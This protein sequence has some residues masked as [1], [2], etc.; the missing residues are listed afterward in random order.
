MKKQLILVTSPPACG[1]TYVSEKLSET[2]KPIIYLDKDT[3]IPLSEQVYKAA[4]VEVNRSGVASQY[5]C[6]EQTYDSFSPSPGRQFQRILC[7]SGWIRSSPRN[8]SASDRKEEQ[9]SHQHRQP[10]VAIQLPA[11]NDYRAEN[12]KTRRHSGPCT[13]T[14][15]LNIRLPIHRRFLHSR[16]RLASFRFHEEALPRYK[17]FVCRKSGARTTTSPLCGLKGATGAM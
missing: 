5:D 10:R 14:A 4:G 11:V 9:R 16:T 13:Q 6:K 1:K 15:P 17:G 12:S 7:R 3:V 2:L 8:Q